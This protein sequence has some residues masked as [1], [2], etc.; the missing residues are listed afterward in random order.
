VSSAAA[1]VVAGG[2]LPKS[3]GERTVGEGRSEGE[4]LPTGARLPVAVS[5]ERADG[6]GRCRDQTV[7]A[8]TLVA[9]R[10]LPENPP[11]PPSRFGSDS[12]KVCIPERVVGGTVFASFL[13]WSRDLAAQAG[14]PEA[15]AR[16]RAIAGRL[17]A[18]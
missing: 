4:N 17:A 14:D 18:Q 11:P 12:P 3:G 8:S 13:A 16:V 1:R 7:V 2:L 15:E 9:S 5:L 10:K 6:L